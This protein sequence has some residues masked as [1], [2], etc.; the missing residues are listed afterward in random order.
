LSLFLCMFLG[1]VLFYSFSCSY[2]VFPAPHMEGTVFPPSCTLASFVIDELMMDAW[3]YFW[4]F[5]PVPSITMSVFVPV[6]YSFDDCSFLCS[7]TWSQG[8]WFHQ[9]YISFSRLF[10][11]S[12]IFRFSMQ[13][14]KFFG[15]S[16][17][18]NAIGNS[19]GIALN[20]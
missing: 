7:I 4:A 17:V 10:W 11:L 18:A 5:C 9:P 20:L 8:A 15:S 13:M 16:S 19:I 2:S 6:P 3:V 12:R 1:S 14:V